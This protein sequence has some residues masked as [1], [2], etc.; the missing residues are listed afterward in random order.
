MDKINFRLIPWHH[1]GKTPCGEDTM[2]GR[3]HVGKT[4]CNTILNNIINAKQQ[5]K[6]KALMQTESIQVCY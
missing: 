1:V 3:H 6:E 4:P 2:W 5:T